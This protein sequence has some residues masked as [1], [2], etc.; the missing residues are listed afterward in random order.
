MVH[1]AETEDLYYQND[2]TV[3]D[4]PSN[5]VGKRFTFLVK[6]YT[7][8][9]TAGVASSLSP[10]MILGDRPDKPSSAP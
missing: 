1:A 9:A 4:F 6:V 10:S 8:F 7:D 3:T 5:A 2:F